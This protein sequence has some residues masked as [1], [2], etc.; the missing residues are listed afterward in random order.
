MFHVLEI[1]SHRTSLPAKSDWAMQILHQEYEQFEALFRS[2]FAEMIEYV[3]VE[4]A[5]QISKPVRT[6]L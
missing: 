4:F 6:N 2:F 3:E 1:M 5:V